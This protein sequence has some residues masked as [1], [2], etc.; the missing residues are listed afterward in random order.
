MRPPKEG[1]RVDGGLL[2]PLCLQGETGPASGGRVA[3][4]ISETEQ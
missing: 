4:V 2:C 1:A 3:M